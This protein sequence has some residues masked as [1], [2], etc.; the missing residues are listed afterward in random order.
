VLVPSAFLPASKELG[1]LL[2][3]S[4]KDETPRVL[5]TSPKI[6]AKNLNKAA[7]PPSDTLK[8]ACQQK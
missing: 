5:P 2:A 7:I 6:I 8:A 1:R 3:N 4:F